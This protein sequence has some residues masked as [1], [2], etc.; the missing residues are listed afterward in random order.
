MITGAQ[1]R[2]ARGHLRWSVK[3]LAESSGVSSAT[4]KRMEEVDDTPK[5]FADN[6]GRVEKAFEA[7]GIEFIAENGGGPGVRLKKT[8]RDVE[9]ISQQ[10]NALEAKISSMPAPTE[11]SPEAGMNIMRKAVAKNDLAK[12]KNPRT[13]IKLPDRSK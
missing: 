5:V 6:L 11:P 4:I 7:A 13:R 10:I 1:I 9:E 12:L 8:A 3:D 2:M